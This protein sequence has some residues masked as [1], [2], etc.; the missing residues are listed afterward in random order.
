VSIVPISRIA[1]RYS[2]NHD[3]RKRSNM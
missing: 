2:L 3:L 1:D